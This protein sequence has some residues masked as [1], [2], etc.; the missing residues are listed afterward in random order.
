MGRK[1]VRNFPSKQLI[2]SELA[3]KLK[4]N[5]SKYLNLVCKKFDCETMEELAEKECRWMDCGWVN[6]YPRNSE[7]FHEWTLDEG[8]YNE[9]IFDIV[10]TILPTQSTTLKEIIARQ[11][12]EDLDYSNDY[13]VVTRLD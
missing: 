3:D 11:L 13:I 10:Y 6:I 9:P 5:K 8:Q 12:L 7:H 1:K 2:E 4:E